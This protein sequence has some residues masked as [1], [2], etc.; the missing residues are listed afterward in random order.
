MEQ[1]WPVN[2]MKEIRKRKQYLEELSGLFLFR[3]TDKTLAENI[4]QDIR[5]K[6]TEFEPGEKIYTPCDFHRSL[7]LVLSGEVKAVKTS[8][9]NGIVLRTLSKGG[10]FGAAGLFT[11][12]GYVAEIS[13]VHRSRILWIP[14]E[15]L[16][17]LFRRNV[18]TAENYIAYL[19]GR[20]CF[21]NNRIN[22]FTAGSAKGKL[23]SFLWN[24]SM[25]YPEKKSEILLPYSMKQ[26]SEMLGIGRTSLYRA[27]DELQQEG[28]L[29][30]DGKR[31]V[32]INQEG[33]NN[34]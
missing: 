8:D 9:G 2:R 28:I 11:D 31:I 10:V 13:A 12:S 15:L 5:C 21:L 14:Q 23:S 32:M 34:L 1:N 4:F 26:L 7:G 17:E 33:R 29:R 3:G 22:H 24:L 16:Q 19:A 25:A 18:T 6:C 20:I 27:F 30:K